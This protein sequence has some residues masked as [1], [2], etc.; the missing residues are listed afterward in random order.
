MAPSQRDVGRA[1]RR[2]RQRHHVDLEEAVTATRIPKRYLEALEDNAP[3]GTFPAPV[4]AR[5]FLREYARYLEIDPEP[6]VARLGPDAEDDTHL[7]QMHEALPPPRRWPARALISISIAILTALAVMG[8][9]SGRDDLPRAAAGF[10][11]APPAVP[12]PSTPPANTEPAAPVGIK[13]ALHV[14]DR[15]WV[16]AVADGTPLFRGVWDSNWHVFRGTSNLALTLGN[17]GGVHL[18]VNGDHVRTGSSG[19]VVRL[20]LSLRNGHVH[21]TRA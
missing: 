14:T 13:A 1:L 5:A 8:A 16:E 18:F 21:V 19:E 2:A 3:I 12:P 9:L 20:S 7:A 11:S 17:A 6:L 15:T 4:Y 10:P